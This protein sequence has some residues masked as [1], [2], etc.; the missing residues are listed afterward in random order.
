M[1][2]LDYS[3]WGTWDYADLLACRRVC[4]G[5]GDN[6]SS[7]SPGSGYPCPPPRDAGDA[8]TSWC[9]SAGEPFRGPWQLVIHEEPSFSSQPGVASTEARAGA[10]AAALPAT[11]RR[12]DPNHHTAVSRGAGDGR[13]REMQRLSRCRA[14]HAARPAA[15]A[16]GGQEPIKSLYCNPL[17]GPGVLSHVTNMRGLAWAVI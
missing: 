2:S 7:M 1:L 4:E 9:G 13:G 11:W 12:L 10:G 6:V 14:L 15:V 3:T 16:R 8:H 5:C 17:A